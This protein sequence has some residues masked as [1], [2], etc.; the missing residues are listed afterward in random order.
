MNKMYSLL[1]VFFHSLETV[2]SQSGLLLYLELYVTV[3]FITSSFPFHL[4]FFVLSQSTVILIPLS[5]SKPLISHFILSKGI[6]QIIISTI[7][8]LLLMLHITHS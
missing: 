5:L 8:I 3:M 1:F 6:V 4:Y 7:V 2:L